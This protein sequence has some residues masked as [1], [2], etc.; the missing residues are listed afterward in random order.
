MGG[1]RTD[2]RS[3]AAVHPA[4][5]QTPPGRGSGEGK[6]LVR[7]PGAQS[8]RPLKRSTALTLGGMCCVR[9]HPGPTSQFPRA[10]RGAQVC[11]DLHVVRSVHTCPSFST[12]H[13]CASRAEAQTPAGRAVTWTWRQCLREVGRAG[14]H[15]RAHGTRVLGPPLGKETVNL[16]R[17]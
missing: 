17:N 12:S 16:G 4:G 1:G 15:T 3:S 9:E 6:R 8:P 11:T 10:L 2:C 14:K 7:P 13:S 5:P